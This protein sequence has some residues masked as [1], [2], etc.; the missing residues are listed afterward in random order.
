MTQLAGFLPPTWETS[1]EFLL[2][3]ATEAFGKLR[4]QTESFSHFL[5]L[6]FKM[7]G[8]TGCDGLSND[9]QR[10]PCPKNVSW[11]P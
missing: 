11:L 7:Y 10:C 4:H 9:P 8:K 5:P 2:A 3:S 6:R 1:T